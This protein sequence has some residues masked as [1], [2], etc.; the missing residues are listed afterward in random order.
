MA[1][2]KPLK[3]TPYVKGFNNREVAVLSSIVEEREIEPG[4]PIA[5]ENAE[6]EEMLIVAKGSL[7]LRIGLPDGKAMELLTLSEGRSFAELALVGEGPRVVSAHAG[8]QGARVL[9]IRRGDFEK[10]LRSDAKVAAKFLSGILRE[11]GA[12]ARAGAVQIKK[13]L[14]ASAKS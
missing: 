8:P 9:S 12:V 11:V 13:I 6:S 7:V 2:I 10:L 5:E 3:A 14:A 4:A 1:K